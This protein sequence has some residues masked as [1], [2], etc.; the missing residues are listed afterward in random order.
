MGKGGYRGGSTIVGP[1]SGWFTSHAPKPRQRDKSTLV[2]NA[3]NAARVEARATWDP[4]IEVSRVVSADE[5]VDLTG[6][7]KRKAN[8]SPPSAKRSGER[9]KAL[10]RKAEKRRKLGIED[11]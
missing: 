5:V 9:L 8:A 1:S 2:G 4:A 10:A 7:G 11:E 6:H 3:A